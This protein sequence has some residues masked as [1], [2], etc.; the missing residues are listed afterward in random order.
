MKAAQK[1]AQMAAQMAEKKAVHLG[2]KMVGMKAELRVENSDKLSV[3]KKV[4]S[5]A[6]QTAEQSVAQ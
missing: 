2:R 4:L 3:V 5:T 1:A 6:E